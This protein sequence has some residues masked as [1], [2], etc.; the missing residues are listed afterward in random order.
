MRPR[1]SSRLD[2]FDQKTP[3]E[4]HLDGVVLF[5]VP[6]QVRHHRR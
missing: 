2:K 5:T 4:C 1:R 3:K 6:S